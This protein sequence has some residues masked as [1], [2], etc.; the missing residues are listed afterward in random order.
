MQKERTALAWNRTALS[1]LV[2]AVVIVRLSSSQFGGGALIGLALTTP[3][4]IS[5]FWHSATR[6][7]RVMALGMGRRQTSCGVAGI[8]LTSMIVIIGIME[9]AALAKAQ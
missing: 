5:V 1:V 9:L 3:L 7:Q 8:S 4:A 6:Y 2:A